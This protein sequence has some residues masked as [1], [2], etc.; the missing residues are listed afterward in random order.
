VVL[1]YLK[2][3]Y[4]HLPGGTEKTTKTQDSWDTSRDVKSGS[5]EYEGMLT[6]QPVC[7]FQ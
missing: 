6:T 7:S 3:L 4:S 1:I 2:L 5:P